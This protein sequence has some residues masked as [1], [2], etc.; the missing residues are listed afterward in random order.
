MRSMLKLSIPAG[1]QQF[2][3]AAGMTAFF[4]ILGRVGT[5]ELAASN[6]LVNMLL[7]V[8]LPGVSK[9]EANQ[10]KAKLEAAGATVEMK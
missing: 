3:F 4:W 2:F 1:L 6:V 7:V 10:V 9:D 5:A 8:I